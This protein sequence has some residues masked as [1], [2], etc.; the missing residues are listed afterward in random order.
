MPAPVVLPRP[1]GDK[2]VELRLFDDTVFSAL[3]GG[4]IG[5]E[6]LSQPP[7]LAACLPDV[8]ALV[9]ASGYLTGRIGVRSEN[10]KK[11]LETRES[12]VCRD[13]GQREEVQS[14]RKPPHTYTPHSQSSPTAITLISRHLLLEPPRQACPAASQVSRRPKGR[15]SLIRALL[16]RSDHRPLQG[17]HTPERV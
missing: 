16:P 1:P 10:T 3:V 2:D 13:R 12:P 7:R 4:A 11:K 15:V 5:V 8:V 17:V 9:T 6:D 14:S